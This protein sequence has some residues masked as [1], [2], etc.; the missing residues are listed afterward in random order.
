[1]EPQKLDIAFGNFSPKFHLS[2]Y[3]EVFHLQGFWE[4]CKDLYKLLGS[5]DFP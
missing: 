5:D 2:A 3:Q 1:M 4:I